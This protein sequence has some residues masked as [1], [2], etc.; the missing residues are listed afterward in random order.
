MTVPW[1]GGK[2]IY[3]NGVQVCEILKNQVFIIRNLRPNG[4]VGICYTTMVGEDA[5]SWLD[6]NYPGWTQ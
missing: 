3:L 2:P 1:L 4:T 6:K 5:R